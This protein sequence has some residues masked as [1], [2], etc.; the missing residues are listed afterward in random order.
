LRQFI[1]YMAEAL[2]QRVDCLCGGS[3]GPNQ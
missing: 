2:Y 1:R 3:A